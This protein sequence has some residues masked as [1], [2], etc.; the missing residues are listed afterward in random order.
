MKTI[1]WNFEIQNR[2]FELKI[3]IRNL[4]WKLGIE[5]KSNSPFKTKILNSKLKFRM[6]S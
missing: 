6:Q 4:K 5:N 1:K 2:I 3:E